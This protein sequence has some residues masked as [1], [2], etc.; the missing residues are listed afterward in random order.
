MVSS[1]NTLFVHNTF[2]SKNDFTAALEWNQNSFFVTCPNANLY[3]ENRLPNYEMWKS[4]SKNICIGTDSLCSNWSLDILSEIRT[5]LKYKSYLD[6]K[7][8]LSWATINGARALRLDDALGSITIGKNPGI[9]WIQD[10][11]FQESLQL[12]E[13]AK[14][15]K[16][17]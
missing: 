9:N 7:E 6:L 15:K 13:N 2:S 14:V 4:F 10:V 17:V 12:G 16:L 1:L 5:I 3:I 11:K 8:I